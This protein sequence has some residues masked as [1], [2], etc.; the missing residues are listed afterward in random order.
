ML[1][2]LIDAWNS[3]SPK[4]K[5]EA[6][7]KLLADTREIFFEGK[8]GLLD[9]ELCLEGEEYWNATGDRPIG[10]RTF[11]QI[12]APKK[13]RTIRACPATGKALFAGK[14]TDGETVLDWTT[15]PEETQKFVAFTRDWD[16]AYPQSYTT[17]EAAE[18]LYIIEHNGPFNHKWKANRDKWEA[19]QRRIAEGKANAADMGVM[20]RVQDRLV[21]RRSGLVGT[22]LPSDIPF[23][24][25]NQPPEL[26]RGNPC[27]DCGV[28]QADH[29]QRH[30]YTPIWTRPGMRL[31]VGCS[32]VDQAASVRL[33]QHLRSYEQRGEMTVITSSDCLP[34]KT[35]DVW[36]QIVLDSADALALIISPSFLISPLHTQCVGVA[37]EQR[38]VVL[39]VLY[40]PCLLGEPFNRLPGVPSK[41]I[42]KWQDQD[43]AWVE[44]ASK[45]GEVAKCS[46]R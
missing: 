30:V 39:P 26:L 38:R 1:E 22:V 37:L 20:E 17:D 2:K 46:R 36:T 10:G 45:I 43:E 25:V 23:G 32:E 41:P 5:E 7:E 24:A 19:L 4:K 34:G 29:N 11:A 31:F 42:T 6:R 15:I 33:R 35:V 13:E 28:D 27:A 3:G 12:T 8:S 40:R 14:A 9:R 44:V 16:A 18:L 21:F